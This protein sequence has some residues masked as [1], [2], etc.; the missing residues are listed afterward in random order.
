VRAAYRAGAKAQGIILNDTQVQAVSGNIG[1]AV[2]QDIANSGEVPQ[3]ITPIV[4][5]DIIQAVTN[6]PGVSQQ[7]SFGAWGAAA[8]AETKL[9]YD[10]FYRD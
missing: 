1:L 10:G 8:F 6:I 4:D 9:G 5:N 3:T 7:L 2:L